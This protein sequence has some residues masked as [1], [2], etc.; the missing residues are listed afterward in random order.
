MAT[1]SR[2]KPETLRAFERKFPEVWRRYRAMRDACDRSGP[3]P[4]KTRELI[5]IGIEVARKRHGGL[6]AHVN[7]ARKAGASSAEIYEA[8]LLAA[9]LAGMPD[10]LDAF[11]AVKSRLR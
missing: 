1:R 2:R 5:K 10:V 3:L 11:L 6:I 7:R 9:P 4:P 8:I